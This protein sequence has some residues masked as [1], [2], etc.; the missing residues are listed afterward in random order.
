MVL[1]SAWFRETFNPGVAVH[2]RPERQELLPQQPDGRAA[3]DVD[4]G[5][6]HRLPRALV[7]VDDPVNAREWHNVE[8]HKAVCSWWD[9]A[10]SS[11]QV[12]PRKS[13]ASR[14]SA[15][16]E[17]DLTGYLLR[18]GGYQHLNLPTEF[19]P[20]RRGDGHEF[21]GAS[22]RIGGRRRAS[23]CSPNSS[24]PRS[25]SRRRSISARSATR[26][27]ISRTRCRPAARSSSAPTSSSTA[28]RICR[29][30]G[31]RSSRAGTSRSRRRP[32][33]TSSSATSGH[34]SRRA[35]SGSSAAAAWAS[36]SRSARCAR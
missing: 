22:G 2:R 27:S 12:D 35:I 21:R 33:P 15:L 32:T 26:R 6:G 20:K 16:H 14:S 4:D 25:S 9:G 7:A 19:D 24:R 17:Q 5:Q 36:A 3:R 23:S 28:R 8:L 13:R 11:R 29:R 1:S 31:T 34:A 30:C 10:M 18:K